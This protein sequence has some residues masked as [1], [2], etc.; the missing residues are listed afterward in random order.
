M[1]PFRSSRRPSGGGRGRRPA[2]S[3]TTRLPRDR[4]AAPTPRGA[5]V[6]HDVGQRLLQRPEQRQL[7]VLRERRAARRARRARSGCRSARRSRRRASAAPAGGR[8][9]RAATGAGR[10]SHAPDAADAGVDQAEQ[11]DRGGCDRRA[12]RY[13]AS[14]PSSILTAEKT[15][16]VSSCSSRDSRRRSSSCCSTMR[17]ES[18]ASS[19]VRAWSRSYRSAFSSAAPTC[20]PSATRKSSSS[21]VN[22]SRASP[23][24]TRAPM[25]SAPV[26]IGSTAA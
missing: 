9:R 21:A 8:G 19:T 10:W 20:C 25:T 12:R 15:C 7:R 22:G 5:R 4:D 18:R 23:T 1:C 11:R 3:S 26:K 24:I 14:T 6:A 2:T 17:A 13:P 16:A